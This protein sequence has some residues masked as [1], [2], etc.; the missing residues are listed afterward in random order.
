MNN[1]DFWSEIAD[2]LLDFQIKPLLVIFSNR[3]ENQEFA[4][5]AFNFLL[6]MRDFWLYLKKKLFKT[7]IVWSF[8]ST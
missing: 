1:E 8:L 7:I 5:N 4:W 2:R 3:V 6:N